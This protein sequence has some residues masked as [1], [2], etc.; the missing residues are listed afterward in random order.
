MPQGKKRNRKATAASR[1]A[2]KIR[3]L[4][5]RIAVLK[6]TAGSLSRAE[7]HA[8]DI[9]AGKRRR[10]TVR[11]GPKKGR[12]SASGPIKKPKRPIKKSKMK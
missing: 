5:K 10:V 2:A 6:K 3:A 1:T 4:E 8:K 7:Q 11:T 12:M 9:H